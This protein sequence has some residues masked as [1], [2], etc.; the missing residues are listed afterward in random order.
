MRSMKL[1]VDVMYLNGATGER[2]GWRAHGAVG[3]K[4]FA[5][6][7]IRSDIKSEQV[8]EA[9]PRDENP[10]QRL[11]EGRCEVRRLNS[12]RTGSFRAF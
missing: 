12:R 2:A 7:T 10:L 5:L 6:E 9:E 4:A 8:I 11:S 3:T 1:C